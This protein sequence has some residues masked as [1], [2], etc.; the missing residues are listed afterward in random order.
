MSLY[1]KI[2]LEKKVNEFVEKQVCKKRNQDYFRSILLSNIEDSRLLDSSYYQSLFDEFRLIKRQFFKMKRNK[3]FFENESQTKYGKTSINE[4]EFLDLSIELGK[5]LNQK[6]KKEALI[7]QMVDEILLNK[8]YGFPK[9][10]KQNPYKN[11]S[12]GKFY[13]G[14]GG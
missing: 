7:E 5:E 11:V 4:K 2:E 8:S 10:N 1:K 14:E 3:E 9:K 12:F 13:S 6:Y